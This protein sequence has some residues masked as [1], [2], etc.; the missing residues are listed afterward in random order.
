MKNS[1]SKLITI[2]MAAIMTLCMSSVVFADAPVTV[3]DS[4]GNTY[5][6]VQVLG[7]VETGSKPTDAFKNFFGN[8]AYGNYTIGTD[9][10]IL[11]K[12]GNQVSG[13]DLTYN[14][15]TYDKA[16]AQAV[17]AAQLQAYAQANNITGT[18]I[19]NGTTKLAKGF[20]LVRETVSSKSDNGEVASKP[21]IV[22][23]TS[24]D[25]IQ[26]TPKNATVDLEKK[27][28]EG[29]KKV[30]ANDVNIGD[31]VNY[32]ITTNFP[33][34][35]IGTDERIDKTKLVFKLT[36]TFSKGLTYN[37]DLAIEG[38]KA[39]TD[40]T[41]TFADGVLVIEFKADTI[42]KN[43]GKAVV[44]TYSAKLNDDAVV[45]STAGN[46]NKVQ[47]DYTHNPNE[48][49]QHKTLKDETRTYTYEFQIRKV[50][51]DNILD[52]IDGALFTIYDS[53]GNVVAEDVS[54]AKGEII[55]VSGL[56][57]GTYTIK[58]TKA[59]D[60]FSL[61]G[62]GI[63]VT[64]VAEENAKGEPTG[65]AEISAS[66]NGVIDKAEDGTPV[67]YC[68]TTTEN[69][70]TTINAV[71]TIGDKK[72][73]ALPQTGSRNAFML[74]LGGA[75]VVLAGILYYIVSLRKEKSAN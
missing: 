4:N 9:G 40:Y 47:L 62:D 74:M 15:K 42:L 51:A 45:N 2:I 26:I 36:D 10:A 21:A 54:P 63:T 56:D 31:N 3:N 37:E 32:E 22:A 14:E 50:D 6:A 71:V 46:V 49:D 38:Y 59:P 69:G 41:A 23:V 60:G 12:D 39:G 35:D 33:V 58:E 64:I 67:S 70:V 28:V 16:S 43:E 61:L 13:G 57:A 30:D 27:I 8:A 44:A 5:T 20:W 11:D 55:K 65:V 66:G 1:V 73:V 52:D 29:D 19:V 68:T 25:P 53:E 17:L 34:Y 48:I 18:T 75:A 7:A 72:G 24:D